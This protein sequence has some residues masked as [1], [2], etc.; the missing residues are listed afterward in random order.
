MNERQ[1]EFVEYLE[2][3][4]KLQ[5]AGKVAEVY[6]DLL[7]D[8][9]DEHLD[10]L[11]EE[12][13]EDLAV[14]GAEVYAEQAMRIYDSTYLSEDE[15]VLAMATAFLDENNSRE[16]AK[17]TRSVF[18]E[19]GGELE[20]DEERYQHWAFTTLKDPWPPQALGTGVDRFL[21]PENDRTYQ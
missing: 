9:L 17:R 20:L 19:Y 15:M 3:L 1:E 4:D 7:K 8:N 14:K 16:I 18:R 6:V 13:R 12:L 5:K 11:P 10:S 2:S 21:E